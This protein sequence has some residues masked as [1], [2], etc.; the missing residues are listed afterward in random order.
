MIQREGFVFLSAPGSVTP[1]HIDPE[2]NFLLQ[3]RGIKEMTV[4]EFPDE[5][6]R[7]LE[8][9]Q[10]ASGAHRNLTYKPT[11]PE[12]FRLE[13]GDAVYVPP[14]APHWVQNGEEASVSLSITFRTPVT[15]RVARA[16]SLNARLRRL[17]LDPKAP[18]ENE[19]VDRAKASVS[20]T[21]GVLRGRLRGS[22]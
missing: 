1:S 5:R 11:D 4:G 13:P 19:T 21:I 16:S 17:R 2:H 6:T 7:Q 8:I 20:K 14:H 9:E 3:I 10:R 15:E 18:G 22:E 12:L